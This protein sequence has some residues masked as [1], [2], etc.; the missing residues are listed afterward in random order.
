[1]AVK[2]TYNT[3]DKLIILNAG[4]TSYDA[5]VDLYSDTKEDWKSDSNLTKFRFPIQ[6]VGGNSIGAGQ[7]ISPYYILLNGWRIRPHEANHILTVV[8]NVI[9]D[10]ESS[11]FIATV[12]SFNVS[13]RSQVTSNSITSGGA[14]GGDATLAKQTEILNKI[15]QVKS[16]TSA[17]L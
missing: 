5:K 15:K 7:V 14:G 11:P 13:I 4:V 1:M 17:G 16:L 6:A 9:T 2:H 10:D 3:S 8:G 12:G